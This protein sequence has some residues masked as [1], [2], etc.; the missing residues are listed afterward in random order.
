MLNLFTEFKLKDV[1]LRN[2]VAVPPM[3]MYVAQ[4]GLPGPWHVSHYGQLA[5]GGAGLVIVEATA[6]SPEGRIT[7]GCAG[8]WNDAQAAVHSQIATEIKRSGAVA[9]IQI[10]H[11]GRKASANLPWEG[12]DH[13]PLGQ[14]G[15]WQAIAPSAVAFGANLPRIPREMT[16][17][18]IERVKED[19]VAAAIRARDAGYQWLELHFAHGYL[20]QS[21]FSP[22]SNQRTD[23]YGGSND[24]RERFLLQTLAAVR[25]VW[26]EKL[27]LAMRFGM[28]EFD[29]AEEETLT[30]S[31]V[32]AKKFR[33]AGLDFLSVSLGFNTPQAKIPWGLGFMVPIA[34]RVKKETGLPVATAWGLGLPAMAESAVR[35]GQID[36]AMVGRAHLQNPH[37][38][39]F[40][41]SE[42]GVEKPMWLLPA[43]Y[44]H[45]LERYKL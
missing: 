23:E 15:S 32:A 14:E 45:W 5:K 24:G 11:A 10:G 27:P 9:G 36:L 20:A 35:N 13:I 25:A 42:L 22:Y 41:A 1:T 44:A 26:P 30:R 33:A 28:I 6:V 18:E 16:R 7:P 8:I 38:T 29:G 43:S 37:W 17:A 40:A 12:D 3:C 19:F 31:I 21:F 4:D 34:H 2:R 39:A